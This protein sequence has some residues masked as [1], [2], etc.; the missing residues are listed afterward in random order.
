MVGS[1]SYAASRSASGVGAKYAPAPSA[2]SQA[3]HCSPAAQLLLEPV[4]APEAAAEVV[5]HVH[6]RRLARAGDH[7]AAVLERAVMAEDDV[8]DRLRQLRGEAVEPL[9]RPADPVVAEHDLPLQA[10]LVGHRDRA[11]SELVGLELADVVQQRAGTATSRSI[12]GNMAEIAL[13]DWATLSECS[14]RPWR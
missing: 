14:S 11:G 8:E 6:E 5:D 3:D 7:R 1:R 10:A 4:E 12:P 9:D 2:L 13:T